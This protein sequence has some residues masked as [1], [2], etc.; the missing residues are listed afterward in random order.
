M[1]IFS[2][3]WIESWA[4][5]PKASPVLGHAPLDWETLS[6][7]RG[8]LKLGLPTG[9]S[10][11]AKFCLPC[12]TVALNFNLLFGAPRVCTDMW[13]SVAAGIFLILAIRFN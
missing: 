1:Q 12:S 13:V 4:S 5:W 10:S 7:A 6:M 2:S 3:E 8:K 9:V 11:M